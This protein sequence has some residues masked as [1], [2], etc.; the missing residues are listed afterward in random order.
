MED[1]TSCGS[2]VKIVTGSNVPG[3]NRGCSAVDPNAVVERS[4]VHVKRNAV[5][6][7]NSV[8]LPGV[9][10][11]EGAVVAAGAVVTKDVGDYELWAGVPAKRVRGLERPTLPHIEVNM[12]MPTVR[13]PRQDEEAPY[14]D[15][16][17]AFAD[18]YGYPI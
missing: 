7:V 10:I 5:L 15:W 12:P 3:P 8:V 1:G 13:P 11:G 4:Y 2:G 18:F 6:F 9:T 17:K 14:E 16:T